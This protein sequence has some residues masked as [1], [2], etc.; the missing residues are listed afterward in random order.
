MLAIWKT[1]VLPTILS[2]L[3]FRLAL[4]LHIY[5][6]GEGIWGTPTQGSLLMYSGETIWASGIEPRLVACK[7]KCPTTVLSFQPLALY[8]FNLNW[9]SNTFYFRASFRVGPF[10][11]LGYEKSSAGTWFTNIFAHS[12]VFFFSWWNSFEVVKVVNSD[13]MFCLLVFSLIT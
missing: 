12:H 11:L 13:E 8:F 7:G 3:P 5:L 6:F 10:L 1:S 9:L 2:L 4:M